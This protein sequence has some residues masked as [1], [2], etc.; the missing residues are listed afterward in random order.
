VTKLSALAIATSLLVAAGAA[1]AESMTG[2]VDS[3]D[4]NARTIVVNGQPYQLE[5]QASGLKIDQIAVG[6]KVTI[7]FDANTNNVSQVDHAK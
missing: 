7:Q 3:V 2:T 4:P 1:M 5:E 6:Q